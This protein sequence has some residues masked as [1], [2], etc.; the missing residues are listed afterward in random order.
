MLS[1]IDKKVDHIKYGAGRIKDVKEHVIWVQFEDP[2]GLK[3]FLYPE[4]FEKFLKTMDPEVE[5]YV[6]ESVRI[7]KEQI[8]SEKKRKQ[9][10]YE[11]KLEAA[12]LEKK[13]ERLAR[14]KKKSVP[15]PKKVKVEI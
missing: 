3:S 1:L 4:A 11:A 6:S 9:E 12:E 2:I 14:T 10:E 5:N 15:K 13:K 8:E 7:L